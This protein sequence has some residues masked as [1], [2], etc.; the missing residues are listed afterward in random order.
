MSVSVSDVSVGGARSDTGT[1][2]A[3]P[4]GGASA[5][6]HKM[7]RPSLGPSSERGDEGSVGGV[8]GHW[9]DCLIP[10]DK[11]HFI[12]SSPPL[13]STRQPL[14][15][16]KGCSVLMVNVCSSGIYDFVFPP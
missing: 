1:V 7:L 13:L 11:T 9:P 12:I 2:T 15:L 10:S 8:S 14:S 6:I 4:V 16:D 3:S 5:D